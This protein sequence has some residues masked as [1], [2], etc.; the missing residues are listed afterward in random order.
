MSMATQQSSYATQ[1]FF[2]TPLIEVKYEKWAL[3]ALIFTIQG[4]GEVLMK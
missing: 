2:A 1:G 4:P 3:S